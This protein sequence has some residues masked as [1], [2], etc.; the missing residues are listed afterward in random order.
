M[1]KVHNKAA[2]LH[3]HEPQRMLLIYVTVGMLAIL[4]L[5]IATGFLMA[6]PVPAWSILA[7]VAACFLGKLIL[8]RA[9]KFWDAE[10][11]Q[12]LK[13]LKGGQIEGYVA[14]M[15]GDL[16]N[17]FHVFNNIQLSPELDLDHVVVGP[18]GLWAISTK[19]ARG[20]LT[21]SHMGE[22]YRNNQPCEWGSEALRQAFDF[23]KLLNQKLGTATPYINAMLAVP[24]AY[25]DVRNPMNHV[26]V[27]SLYDLLDALKTD[28]P[29][30][31][32]NPKQV[33]TV[34]A[35]IA[36]MPRMEPPKRK[37]APVAASAAEA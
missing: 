11:K 10:F 37:P 21:T 18:T 26:T 4:A 12:K 25:T 15:L 5:G 24:L 8:K 7:F 20:L 14:W 32:L 1:A 31:P 19:D 33:T 22:L 2:Q 36:E 16:P 17:G 30:H 9:E 13:Y 27:V 23:K 35:A 3:K 28:K 6:A 34:V 29:K